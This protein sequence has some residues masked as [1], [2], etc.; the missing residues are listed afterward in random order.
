[1]LWVCAQRILSELRGCKLH[2]HGLRM[3]RFLEPVTV[4][5]CC[6]Q[7]IVLHGK[8]TVGLS[9]PCMG[10]VRFWYVRDALSVM[11][12]RANNPKPNCFSWLKNYCMYIP[13]C[14]LQPSKIFY[15]QQIYIEKEKWSRLLLHSKQTA[16]PL[17]NHAVWTRDERQICHHWCGCLLRLLYT[18]LISISTNWQH[19]NNS[20][21]KKNHYMWT[22]TN[23]DGQ[24]IQNNALHWPIGWL[25]ALTGDG[26]CHWWSAQ[27]GFIICHEP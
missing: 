13:P 7:C 1:M 23:T 16:A 22:S 8:N 14:R 6:S 9:L 11:I 27:P 24:T 5:S 21:K 17:Q 18:K 26:W 4:I 3:A 20:S 12:Y 19:C 15:N 10:T 2:L 25:T